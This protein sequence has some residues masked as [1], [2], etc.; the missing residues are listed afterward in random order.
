MVIVGATGDLAM[1][2][3]YRA[4][5]YR[6]R[7]GQ[8]P[9]GRIIGASRTEMSRDAFLGKLF[10][11]AQRYI[12]AEHRP[13][14]Q[15]Q[16]FIE[17]L[18][19]L[20]LDAFNCDSYAPL[21][22]KLNQFPERQRIFYFSTGSRIFAPMCECLY[23][24]ELI[25]AGARVVLEKPVGTD[26][27]SA[28]EINEAVLQYFDE[29]Q[30]FRID[31]YLGK[32][33]VQ[34]LM[35]L[36][37]GNSMF[38]SLWH[39]TYIDHIQITV[40]ESLGVEGRAGFYDHTGALR[41]M[42]QSHLLQL[43]CIIAMEPPPSIEADVVRD[44]KL[45]VLRSL[46]PLLDGDIDTHVVRGQYLA[47]AVDGQPVP[48]YR[49]EDGVDAD[50]N[51]ETYVALKTY[52]DNWRWANVP[53]YLRTGKRLARR[54]SEIVIHFRAVP[55]SIFGEAALTPNRLTIRLQ[56]EE[57]IQLLLSG[58]R[59]GTGM[60]VRPLEL[61][62][63]EDQREVDHVPDAYER[64]LMDAIR[65]RATLFVRRDE[66]ETAWRWIEPITDRWKAQGGRPDTYVAST[67]G[68]TRAAALLARDNR[69]W[70]EGC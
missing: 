9:D 5:Y 68:P 54:T 18:D 60:S 61:N 31:H 67:W 13:D 63:D 22:E 6:F 51:T 10:E 8:L 19:Y 23:R 17:R 40:A 32:E 16:A 44:E 24:H 34:N 20:P 2:K 46:R 29:S 35:V 37:F 33:P 30:V 65:G 43:L 62:L 52:I 50:S 66:L 42:V 70:D 41:D 25:N 1:R 12:P 48:A 11:A 69:D 7:D 4:L 57:G 39:Q 56:P 64:L 55:H 14:E 3:L 28:I 36:R 58:K 15:W 38:E 59:I 45:K 21:A 53:F 49:N 27:A 47:G 26:L